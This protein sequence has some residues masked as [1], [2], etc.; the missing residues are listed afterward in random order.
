MT[1]VDNPLTR[2]VRTATDVGAPDAGIGMTE[3]HGGATRPRRASTSAKEGSRKRM[4]EHLRRAVR[5]DIDATG[6]VQL[7]RVLDKAE[8]ALD[9]K[10]ESDAA[11]EAQERRVRQLVARAT[12]K[13]VVGSEAVMER[14]GNERIEHTHRVK[15]SRRKRRYGEFFDS[16]LELLNEAGDALFAR[17]N[18]WR[19]HMDLFWGAMVALCLT[20]LGHLWAGLQSWERVDWAWTE[21]IRPLKW[22]PRCFGRRCRRWEVP[23][24]GKKW[25]YFGGVLLMLAEPNEGGRIVKRTLRDHDDM[26][27]EQVWVDGQGY[28]LTQR[29]R[30][31]DAVRA[32]NDLRNADTE[33]RNGLVLVL[34]EDVPG[35]VI[36]LIFVHRSV[37]LDVSKLQDDPLLLLTVLSTLAHMARQLWEA[38]ALWRERPDLRLAAEGDKRFGADATDDDVVRYAQRV[39]A[40]A[41]RVSFEPGADVGDAALRALGEHCPNL[42]GVDLGGTHVHKKNK[43]T[44]AGVA[45]L[46]QDCPLL[47]AINFAF[48]PELTDNSATALAQ[49]CTQLTSV[50]FEDAGLWRL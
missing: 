50:N 20:V 27:G 49:A 43:V 16:A 36:Q 34:L 15:Q 47:V 32:E 6:T 7:L 42:T 19:A 25:R 2:T 40:H 10:F 44:D 23:W 17:T 18:L 39:K 13:L 5:K 3:L 21:R 9:G 31:P 37:G 33:M 29:E 1:S 48:C 26:A 46:A 30:D 35:L 45:A 12:D 28:V 41:R 14:E 38:W 4:R 24:H 8:A 22:L 11:Y